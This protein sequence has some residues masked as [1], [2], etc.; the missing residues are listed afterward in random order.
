MEK[1]RGKFQVAA[2]ASL[3]MTSA[4]CSNMATYRS[5]V[6]QWLSAFEF[7]CRATDLVFGSIHELPKIPRPLLRDRLNPM[8]L[9]DEVQ[10]LSR[11]R[12]T[13]A[14]VREL[15]RVLPLAE[16]AD[17]RGQ[18]LTPMLQLYA[19][20][21]FQVV[22]SDLIK[23]SQPTV[24]RTVNKVTGLIARHLFRELVHFPEAE[25][26]GE[27]MHA[28]YMIGGFPG[29][30]GCIACTHVRIKSPGGDTAEVF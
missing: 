24:C 16:N 22:T 7:A 5:D 6:M 29:V 15:L 9:Y 19:H 27:V 10:F 3:K 4:Q 14:T 18:P 21:T 23:V 30:T 20:G 11:Y 8:K 26:Y 2:V 12:F 17:K 1:K 13:K 25:E 28:F